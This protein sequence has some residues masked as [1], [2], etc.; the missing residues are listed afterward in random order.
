MFLL[1]IRDSLVSRSSLIEEALVDLELLLYNLEQSR[2]ERAR[3]ALLKCG[4]GLLEEE[5]I[6]VLEVWLRV[7]PV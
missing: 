5:P 1:Y 4:E 2:V 3:A 6:N 7:A